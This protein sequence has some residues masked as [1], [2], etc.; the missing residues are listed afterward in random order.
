M[1]LGERIM[2]V[3]PSN[4][5]LVANLIILRLHPLLLQSFLCPAQQ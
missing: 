1:I 2:H 3:F 4:P 5:P